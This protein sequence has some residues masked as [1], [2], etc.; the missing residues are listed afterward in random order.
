MN[1]ETSFI[2]RLEENFIAIILALMVFISFSQVIARYVFHAGWGGALE[3]TQVLFAWLIL[4]GMSY[5][6]KMG[7]HLGVDALIRTFPK[8]VFRFFSLFG[9]FICILYGL[10]LFSAEWLTIF[11]LE[12]KGGAW[13]YFTK[14]Y[15]IGI[16]MED[17]MV[18]GFFPDFMNGGER[19]P[20][21]IA[22]LILPIGLLLFV[23]RSV[24]AF[25][26]IW[27]GD[28]EMIIASHEA[29]ELVEENKNVI[30]D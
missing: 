29:E 22:Y 23:F 11:G 17:V 28:R 26:A 25:I 5:G 7:S 4:F 1:K 14:I 15:Q 30:K 9:A 13:F 21:W 24:Q 2:D 10:T 16:G 8:P 18:P 20:R 6:V 12:S 3:L 19:L 27:K